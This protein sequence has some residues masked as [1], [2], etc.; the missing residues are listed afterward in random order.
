MVTSPQPDVAPSRKITRPGNYHLPLSE[1]RTDSGAQA[2]ESLDEEHV[3]RL[4]EAY[5]SSA[6]SVAPLIVFGDGAD[7]WLADGY[8]RHEAQSRRGDAEVYVDLRKGGRRDAQLYGAG[9][10]SRHGLPRSRADKRRAVLRLLA[11]EEWGQ[12]SDRRIADAAAVSHTMV[13]NLRRELAAPE[14]VA[15]PPAPPPAPP[16]GNV[17]TPESL[18][19]VE[20]PRAEGA[21]G[22]ERDP[23]PGSTPKPE[24]PQRAPF[25]FGTAMWTLRKLLKEWSAGGFPRPGI[26]AA[27]GRVEKA[28]GHRIHED[29]WEEMLAC[30]V[31]EGFWTLLGPVGKPPSLIQALEAGPKTD[32]EDL[33]EDPHTDSDADDPSDELDPDLEHHLALVRLALER[34]EAGAAGSP[35][36]EETVLEKFCEL[37]EYDELDEPLWEG[38]LEEGVRRLWWRRSGGVLRAAMPPDEP[39]PLP[40]DQRA[41]LDAYWTPDMH[42]RGLM[43]WLSRVNGDVGMWGTPGPVRVLEPAAGGGAWLR[44]CRELWPRVE[45][46]AIDIDPKAP[47]LALA[48]RAKVEDFLAMPTES[49]SSPPYSLVVGN[50]PYGADLVRWIDQSRRLAPVV[51]Y[52]LRSTFLGAAERLSWWREHPPSDVVVVLPRPA[53]EG[54]GARESTDRVDSVF[55]LWREGWPGDT[56]LHWLDVR[57]GA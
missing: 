52:L 14:V 54:P 22:T 18:T 9:A 45:L 19:D 4:V 38:V 13:A 50:P 44:A 51:A 48:D 6:T 49:L 8:H 28:L 21:G 36:R 1:I 30:G 34:L 35:W 2:R 33:E 24:E 10:N 42:A 47:G 27:R 53:W 20:P 25:D 41:E 29:K 46:S 12:W 37:A 56:Q 32:V 43:R 7:Y 23:A 5:H 57:E 17:A 40:N 31:R 15:D 3:E 55:V 26:D 11:D 16:G 39:T